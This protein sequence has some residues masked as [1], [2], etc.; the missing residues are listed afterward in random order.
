MMLIRRVVPLRRPAARLFSVSVDNAKGAPEYIRAAQ[1]A[2]AT[3]QGSFEEVP[4]LDFAP[5]R[6]G[7]AA[8]KAEIGARLFAICE[9]I[10]FVTLVNHGLPTD[11]NVRTFEQSEKFFTGL[12]PEQKS[13][14]AWVS[15]ESNRG[16]LGMGQEVLDGTVPDLKETFEIGNERETTY[17]NRWPTAELPEFRET[18]LEYFHAA[19][20][21][22]LDVLR[23][24]AIGMNLGE[25]FFTPL[26]DGNHQNL[27]L[28]HYPPSPRSSITAAGQKRGGVHSD[29][30]SITLLTQWADQGGLEACRKDGEWVFVPPIEGSVIVNVGD[31]M[32]RWSNDVLRSTPHCVMDDPRVEGDAVPARYSIAYFCNP[33]K[34]TVVACL[35]TCASDE[36][37]PAYPPIK[38]G[39]YLVSRVAALV[40]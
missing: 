17:A 38:A 12:S 11:L 1:A 14:Y 36:R 27:R 33:S 40:S 13:N 16:Y 19:D 24:L 15:P 28:L 39:D 18:M 22:H 32:M 30:G 9:D 10:G 6:T 35:P 25:D 5:W 37:P 20:M 3:A 31:C 34:D 7:D 8:Q 2:G 26:C 23:C 21:L 29:Y 4:V